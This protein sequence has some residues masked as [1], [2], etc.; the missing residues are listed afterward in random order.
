MLPLFF[1]LTHA[2][3]RPLQTRERA[4]NHI[5]NS[6]QRKNSPFA[7]RTDRERKIRSKKLSQPPNSIPQ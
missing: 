1:M 3:T 5:T 7:R 2:K 6:Q 4:T